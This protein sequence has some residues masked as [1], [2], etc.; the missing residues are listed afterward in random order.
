MPCR[1]ESSV[2]VHLSVIAIY[3]SEKKDAKQSLFDFCP[4]TRQDKEGVSLAASLFIALGIAVCCCS[5]QS[6]HDLK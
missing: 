4:D 1:E 2:I 6:I 5:V 3:E